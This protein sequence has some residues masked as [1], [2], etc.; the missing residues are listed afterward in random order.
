[1]A[2]ELTLKVTGMTCGGCESA[3][4]RAV[5]MVG[6]VSDVMASHRDDKVVVKYDPAKA[7]RAAIVHAIQNAGYAVAG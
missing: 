2:E 3:V 1:M 4:R 5:S 7:D 6:G